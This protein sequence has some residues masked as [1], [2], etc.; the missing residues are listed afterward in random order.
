MHRCNL[1]A[2]ELGVIVLVKQEELDDA[3][4]EA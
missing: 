1:F 3:G 2:V 4:G